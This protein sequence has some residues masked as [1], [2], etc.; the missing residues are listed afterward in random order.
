ME[1]IYSKDVQHQEESG[2]PTVS[3][4]KR[5]TKKYS[6]AEGYNKDRYPIIYYQTHGISRNLTH[7]SMNWKLPSDTYKKEATLFSQ[8]G[9]IAVTNKPKP[10]K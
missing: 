2:K 6:R 1:K 4:P 10:K 3:K 7:S 5:T 9:G 8:I